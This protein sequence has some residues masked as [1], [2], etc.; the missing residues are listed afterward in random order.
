[1]SGILTNLVLGFLF[2]PLNLLCLNFMPTTNAFL[3]FV[4][5]LTYFVSILNISLAI[6]N[7]LP[8]YPLDGFNFI[9][10]FLRK[11]NKFTNFMVRYGTFILLAFVLVISYTNFFEIV[12]QGLFNLFASFWRLII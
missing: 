3:I 6:F 8:I 11:E 1:M 5:Y 4:Y 9:N 12:I 2:I 7:I 10:S